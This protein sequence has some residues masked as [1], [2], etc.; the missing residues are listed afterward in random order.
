[1]TESPPNI[2]SGPS[3]HKRLILGLTLLNIGL[4]VGGHSMGNVEGPAAAGPAF[5]PELFSGLILIFMNAVGLVAAG[6]ALAFTRSAK[7]DEMT[8][9]GCV[10]LVLVFIPLAIN[11]IYFLAASMKMLLK[12]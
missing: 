7:P 10:V 9:C 4:F 8:G 1:M 5:T 3:S 11:T 6:M 12:T 2:T